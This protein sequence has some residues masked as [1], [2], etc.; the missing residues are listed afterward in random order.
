MKKEKLLFYRY[1]NDAIGKNE[2][3]IKEKKT[4]DKNWFLTKEEATAH[5]EEAY[6]I[7][8]DRYEKI[9]EGIEKLKETL[10]DFSYEYFLLGDTNGIYDDGLFIE[11]VVNGYEFEFPQDSKY[12]LP[13]P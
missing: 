3:S 1:E 10:G 12:A 6:K 4:F 8:L 13:R 9:I 7:A 5:F 11:I 2:F